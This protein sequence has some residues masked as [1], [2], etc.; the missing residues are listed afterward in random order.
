M[1]FVRCFYIRK[2]KNS[3]ILLYFLYSSLSHIFSNK[4]KR[5][6]KV[7]SLSF[8][9]IANC[10]VRIDTS[11]STLTNKHDLTHSKPKK[12]QILEKFIERRLLIAH[13]IYIYIYIYI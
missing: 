13:E 1:S 6:R 7:T 8:S 10:K 9:H 4:S 2:V 11:T 3:S 12:I 5:D